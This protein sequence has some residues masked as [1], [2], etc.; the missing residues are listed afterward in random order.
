MIPMAVGIVLAE[1]LND[2][3]KIRYPTTAISA[4]IAPIALTA[5]E[6]ERPAPGM[7]GH[8]T[9]AVLIPKAELL[10]LKRR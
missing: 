6:S 9:R 8:Y 1:P 10:A 7:G 3:P 4:T 5:G 2:Q